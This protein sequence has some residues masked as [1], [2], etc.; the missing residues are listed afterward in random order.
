MRAPATSMSACT[1]SRLA[2]GLMVD[3]FPYNTYP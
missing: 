2:N 3:A 1:H